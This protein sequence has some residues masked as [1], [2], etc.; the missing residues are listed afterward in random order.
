MSR[1]ALIIIYNHKYNQNIPVLEKLYGE[2][3]KNIY[4]LVPFY[5]GTKDNVIPVYENSFYFQGYIAQGLKFFYLPEYVHYIF[6]A[7]DLIL[8]PI[9]NENNYREHFKLNKD[10]CFLPERITLHECN[11]G[12]D[13]WERICDA[14]H[15]RHNNLFGLETDNELPNYETALK[16]FSKHGLTISHFQYDQVNTPMAKP[17]W[18]EFFKLKAY[19]REQLKRRKYRNTKFN[20]HYPLLGSYSDIIIVS[21]NVIKRFAHYCGVLAANKLFV[22]FAIPTAMVLSADTIIYKEQ[23]VLQTKPLWT[24]EDLSILDQYD[25]KLESLLAYFPEKLLFLHPVKLSKWQ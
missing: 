15:Y 3:F 1:I 16:L 22:E 11:K 2:R 14:F 6:I 8:N 10:T 17:K 20:L 25:F 21:D 18:N 12:N 4:H 5:T 23:L 24:K 7:D 13:R 9:I 19:Y